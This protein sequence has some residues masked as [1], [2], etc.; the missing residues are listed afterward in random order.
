M[1]SIGPHNEAT[2][3]EALDK[4]I[5]AYVRFRRNHEGRRAANV[6]KSF[7]NQ[8]LAHS[9]MDQS[10]KSVP[11]FRELSLL[12]GVAMT[13]AANARLAILGRSWDIED[14]RKEDMRQSRAFWEPAIMGVIKSET[15]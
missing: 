3:L 4:T 13:V 5:D 2:A 14:T 6:L 7:R 15:R 10:M 9:L 1:S 12:L 8:Q 11:R